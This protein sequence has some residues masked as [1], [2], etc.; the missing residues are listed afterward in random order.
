MARKFPITTLVGLLACTG[1]ALADDLSKFPLSAGVPEDVFIAVASRPNPKRAFLDKYW[2]EVFAAFQKCGVLED[3]WGLIES[4]VSPADR[5]RIEEALAKIRRL[6]TG[7][8]WGELF[9]GES[10]YMG[11]QALP[12]WENCLLT[13]NTA[14]SAERNFRGLA[15]I[16]REIARTVG[17]PA[18]VEESEIEGAKVLRLAFAPD[19]PVGISIARR[20]DVIVLGIGDALLRDSLGMLA[21]RSDKRPLTSTKRFKAALAMLPPPEDQFVF[22][23][24]NRMV[25]DMRT[26]FGGLQQMAAGARTRP[27]AGEQQSDD[28]STAVFAVIEAVLNDAAIIDYSMTTARTEGFRVIEDTVTVLS[29]DAKK[30]AGYEVFVRA[31]RFETL[32]RLV[33]KEAT[34]FSVS[35]GFNFLG[36]YDWGMRLMQDRVPGGREMLSQWEDFQ[37]QNEF[38]LR[39]DVLALLS[40]PSI[41]VTFGGG[42][43]EQSVTLLKVRDSQRAE[44]VI[45]D[46]IQRLNALLGPQQGLMISNV[47]VPGGGKFNSVGHPMLMMMQ[48]KPIIW[49]T[50][51]DHLIFGSDA[52]SIARCLKTMAG[53]HPGIGENPRFA[54]EGVIPKGPFASA[55]F[56]DTSRTAEDLGAMLAGFSMASGMVGAFAQVPDEQGGQL[57]KAIPSI[58]GKLARVAARLNFFQSDSSVT[59]FD[60]KAWR[61]TSYTNYKDP[62]S[63]TSTTD[64]EPAGDEDEE[65]DE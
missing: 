7:V 32:D 21:G 52:Q 64:N 36:L 63:L 43:Q 62:K 29:P 9:G 30:R 60:G 65:G 51:N 18:A 55:S 31:H 19:V 45:G 22:F 26:T 17:S 50:A 38:N 61:T 58:T 35:D 12:T 25:G 10:V 27:A 23:D 33:P 2:Q 56:N 24:A 40:G 16:L 11:R 41:A 14:A 15:A 20:K 46:L 1:T 13:R 34:A 6:G 42:G 49:G 39:D 47:N 5:E 44:K 48:M 59:T 28:P 4:S 3:V 54:A 8:E 37:E 57:L 53:K